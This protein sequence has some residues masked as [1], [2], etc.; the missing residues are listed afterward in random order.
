[1]SCTGHTGRLTP[2]T[3]AA[4]ARRG[5]SWFYSNFLV[6]LVLFRLVDA[7]DATAHASVAEVGVYLYIFTIANDI[8]Q[9]VRKPACQMDCG[10]QN[11]SLAWACIL[12]ITKPFFVPTLLADLGTRGG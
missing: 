9:F 5:Q 6:V 2:L 8:V 3:P 10:W 11:F 4:L 12:L 1:M 7:E